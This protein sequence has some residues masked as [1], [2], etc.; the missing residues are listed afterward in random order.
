[1]SNLTRKP[2]DDLR[3]HAADRSERIAAMRTELAALAHTTAATRRRRR[4]LATAGFALIVLASAAAAVL[5][6]APGATQQHTTPRHANTH[7]ATP[8]RIDAATAP[9][10]PLTT[11]APSRIEILTARPA[12]SIVIVQTSPPT[13]IEYIDDPTL[14]TLADAAG[15]PLG[16]ARIDNRLSVVYRTREQ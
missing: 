5:T 6:A 11:P 15:T 10:L 14:I 3:P 16:T 8:T 12:S 1:M 13:T 9:T 4:V 7:T 2:A